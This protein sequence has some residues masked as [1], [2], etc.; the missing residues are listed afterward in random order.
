[1]KKAAV[2]AILMATTGPVWA[3]SE[4]AELAKLSYASTDANNDG[5]VSRD[6]MMEQASNIFVSMDSD[7]NGALSLDEYSSWDFGFSL[8]AEEAGRV[9][10]YETALKFVFNM[11]DRDFDGAVTADEFRRGVARDFARVDVNGDFALNEREFIGGFI[12]NV[13]LRSA[14]KVE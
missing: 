13:A 3:Q 9:Q 5:V 6:E 12:V 7:D 10:A 11:W 2:I 4:G 14:L 8:I 1:M